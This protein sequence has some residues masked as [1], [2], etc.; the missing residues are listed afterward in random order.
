[1]SNTTQF[2]PFSAPLRL[3]VV[4]LDRR[5]LS[6]VAHGIQGPKAP[7]EPFVLHTRLIRPLKDQATHSYYTAYL[8]T[9]LLPF[10]MASMEDA[11]KE[12]RI[13]Y[14]LVDAFQVAFWGCG[15]SNTLKLH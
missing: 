3:F 4:M 1:M 13:Y 10:D 15:A 2:R 14:S 11:L 12:R 8:E 5:I 6:I 7:G 9:I